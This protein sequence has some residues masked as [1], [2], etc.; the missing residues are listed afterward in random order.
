MG[1]A[2][3]LFA[4]TNVDDIFVLVAFF[5]DRAFRGREVVAG[6]VLG[7]G[8]LI[9]A[10]VFLSTV[11]RLVPPRYV[12]LLGVIPIV[13]GVFKLVQRAGSATDEKHLLRPSGGS[14]GRGVAV[15]LTTMA[16]G[17]DNIGV[18]VPMFATRTRPELA[19]TIVGFLLL[20]T[21]WCAAGHRLV[22]HPRS[23][24]LLRLHARRV[25]P[26]VFIAL[27]LFI[28]INSRAYSL[29]GG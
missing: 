23:G 24:T 12:G 9:A 22:T 29:L 4:S 19:V 1:L 28:L 21:V 6:Q 2:V 25:T 3:L 26:F 5:S 10:S 7:M 18:Y 13:L 27:G 8:A 11:A 16:T 20:T 17:G 14:F 15:G